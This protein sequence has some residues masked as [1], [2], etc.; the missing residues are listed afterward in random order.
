MSDFS[1]S[2]PSARDG[3]E[4]DVIAPSLFHLSQAIKILCN[5]SL[6]DAV[7]NTETL[8]ATLCNAAGTPLLPSVVSPAIAGGADLIERLI[9]ERFDSKN[10]IGSLHPINLD[11]KFELYATPRGQF[12]FFLTKKVRPFESLTKSEKLCV[13]GL[14]EGK[15][16]KELA[17]ELKIS[18]STVST[19]VSRAKRKLGVFK[20]SELVR[21][22]RS[23]N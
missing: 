22:F 4:Q 21:I 20:K 12:T 17:W 11:G 8:S 9:T 13:I 16:Q 6:E 7:K 3:L 15:S 19:L 1:I 2:F 14:V 10:R 5:A 23:T 18:A